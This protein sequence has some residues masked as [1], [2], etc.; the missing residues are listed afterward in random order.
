M[1]NKK[2]KESQKN[3]PVRFFSHKTL[4]ISE[5]KLYCPGVRAP[6]P[7]CPRIYVCSIYQLWMKTKLCLNSIICKFIHTIIELFESTATW[8]SVHKDP[9]KLYPCR[10]FHLIRLSLPF[11]STWF[12]DDLRRNCK[13]N[14]LR[15]GWVLQERNRPSK[16]EFHWCAFKTIH[17]E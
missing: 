2:S 12:M 13:T 11:K 7:P 9:K 4:I 17:R 16:F 15:W 3:M 8:W 5:M 14:S 6:L 10:T 1:F